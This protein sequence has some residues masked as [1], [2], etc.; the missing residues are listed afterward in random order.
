MRCPA[1][2][3]AVLALAACTDGYPDTDTP[4]PDLHR[5]DQRGRLQALN[6]AAAASASDV[7]WRF[8]LSPDCSLHA[9]RRRLLGADEQF[10]LPLADAETQLRVSDGARRF[11]LVAATT[12]GRP[13]RVFATRSRVDAL[14]ADLALKLLRRDCRP[15]SRVG[16]AA[17]NPRG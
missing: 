17:Y 10:V 7:D 12:D 16:A 3:A 11:E 5:L 8:R 4:T 13:L 14:R 9:Q 2:A 15:E 1:L 6:D